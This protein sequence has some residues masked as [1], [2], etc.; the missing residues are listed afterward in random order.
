MSGSRGGKLIAL[1]ALAGVCLALWLRK[2]ATETQ[3]APEP[4]AQSNA[5][6]VATAAP[7]APVV[8]ATVASS[9]LSSAAS[10]A[11]PGVPAGSASTPPPSPSASASLTPPSVP[12]PPE[13]ADLAELKT[14]EILC[15]QKDPDACYR[16]A[17]AYA[18]GK[19]LPADP[20]RAESYRK[21][22]QTQLFRQCEKSSVRSCLVLAERYANGD[23]LPVD[24]KKSQKLLRHVADVC[25]RKPAPEC[26]LLGAAAPSLK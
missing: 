7:T 19:L 22:E 21:V 18:A 12:P 17:A 1:G 3:A 2:P 9:A 15:Y 14:A 11:P 5:P 10:S 6:P 25:A 24:V 26:S 20:K 13:V 4:K 23:G 8:A 16:A